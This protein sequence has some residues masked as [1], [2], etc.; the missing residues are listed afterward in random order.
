MNT[1]VKWILGMCCLP[2]IF[3]IAIYHSI[4]DALALSLCAGGLVWIL[5]DR[6]ITDLKTRLA[7]LENGETTLNASVDGLYRGET[8]FHE[9]VEAVG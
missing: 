1:T 3:L 2:G 5:F 6:R 9:S 8:T 4:L 7:I